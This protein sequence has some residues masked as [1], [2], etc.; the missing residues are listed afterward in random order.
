[1]D[2]RLEIRGAGGAVDGHRQR[3]A[4]GSNRSSARHP[5]HQGHIGGHRIDFPCAA[6]FG[7]PK[8]ERRHG[9]EVV[10]DDGERRDDELPGQT[11]HGAERATARLLGLVEKSTR[12]LPSAALATD[13]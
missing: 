7:G 11:R 3:A 2:R 13:A 5:P 10:A 1:M 8:H 4:A 9:K 6:F 12:M